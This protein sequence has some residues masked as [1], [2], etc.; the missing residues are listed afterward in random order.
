MAA[1]QRAALAL[2]WPGRNGCTSWGPKRF[3]PVG[4]RPYHAQP[5][6]SGV[7]TGPT[8]NAICIPPEA[9]AGH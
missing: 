6:A 1:F 3:K 2:P 4:L 5:D 9:D 7:D 8:V